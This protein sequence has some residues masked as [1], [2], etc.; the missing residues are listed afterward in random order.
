MNNEGFGIGVAASAETFKI[1]SGAEL[2]F[3][4]GFEAFL[5][6]STASASAAAFDPRVF[7]SVHREPSV[8]GESLLVS[9]DPE[10]RKVRGRLTGDRDD[11][12]NVMFHILNGSQLVDFR[13]VN[14]D[15]ED[16]FFL[17]KNPTWEFGKDRAMLQRL[18]RKNHHLNLTLHGS[19]STSGSPTST[20][21][22]RVQFAGSMLSIRYGGDVNSERSRL[23]HHAT[24]MSV[25][26]LWKREKD[27]LNQDPSFS[28]EWTRAEAEQIRVKGF[29]DKFTVRA[30]RDLDLYP[31]L[32]NDLDN[33]VFD[34]KDNRSKSGNNLEWRKKTRKG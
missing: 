32:A 14:K 28:G 3:R 2:A 18:Q 33:F 4:R 7:V 13:T 17:V 10:T 26:R 24:R 9:V 6:V 23:L 21:D 16:V 34:D 20:Q 1:V 8:L 25:K 5:D 30:R 12:S 19:Q 27:R 29:A 31:E 22:I 11:V 15:N